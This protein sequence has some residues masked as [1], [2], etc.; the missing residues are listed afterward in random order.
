MVKAGVCKTPIIGSNPIVASTI[1][2]T[3]P[4]PSRAGFVYREGG[5]QTDCKRQAWATNAAT[6]SAASSSR[7]GTAWLYVSS[8]M[9]T[10]A[11]PSRSEITL[12]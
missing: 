5:L 12:G 3:K 6:F 10:E 9:L 1:P 4:A 8:V 7:A 2:D 11:W